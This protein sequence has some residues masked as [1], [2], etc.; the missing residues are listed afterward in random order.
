MS[1]Q[2]AEVLS[3][4][5]QHF[6][7][8][9]LELSKRRRRLQLG[10]IKVFCHSNSKSK[11]SYQTSTTFPSLYHFNFYFLMQTY[12]TF[13]TALLLLTS[14]NPEQQILL[15]P[16]LDLYLVSI[17]YH[18]KKGNLC[19]WSDFFPTTLTFIKEIFHVYPN[20]LGQQFNF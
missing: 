5:Q 16:I 7:K 1:C 8:L 10:P 11:L 17:S 18:E 13:M 3:L 19:P 20:F 6:D 9:K 14:R 15:Q 12:Q 4:L 2:H